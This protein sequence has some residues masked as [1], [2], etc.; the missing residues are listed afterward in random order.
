MPLLCPGYVVA[1]SLKRLTNVDGARW[2][3]CLPFYCGISVR[4]DT[5]HPPPL[6]G[7]YIRR[8][9]RDVYSILLRGSFMPTE[10][11]A[12]VNVALHLRIASTPGAWDEHRSEDILASAQRVAAAID[13]GLTSRGALAIVQRAAGARGL[14]ALLTEAFARMAP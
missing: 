8:E 1:E 6:H 14:A 9:K 11:I 5:G 4:A 7:A 13:V 12:A 10:I 2:P 3:A